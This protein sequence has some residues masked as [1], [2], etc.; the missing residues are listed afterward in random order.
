MKKTV[1]AIAFLGM[2]SAHA[3][4]AGVNTGSSMTMG[5]SSTIYSIQSAGNNPAMNS[6][7]VP[8]SDSWRFSYFPD[9]GI[10]TE[11]GEVDNFTDDLD[12]LIDIIDDP[13]STNDSPSEVLNRF[14]TTLEAMGE[15]GYL[16]ST[17]GFGLPLPRLV[18]QSRKFG[19]SFGVSASVQGQAGLR[20]L[21]S[22]LSFDEQNGTFSTASSLYLKSGIEKSVSLSYSQPL[23]E[24]TNF[25]YTRNNRLYG[26]VSARL[27]SLALSKQVTPL[28]QLD[29]RDVSNLLQDEYDNNLNETV[30]I[31]LSVG[32]VWDAVRYRVGLTLDNINSPSFDYGIIGT[33][34]EARQENTA[35]RTNCE[36]AAQFIQQDG[37]I[38]ARETHTMHARA[39]VD[40]LYHINDRWIASGS[41]DLARY[42]DFV[43]FE[44][45]W[46]NVATSYEFRNNIVPSVRAGYQ[47]NLAGEK[48]G[49]LT[50]GMNFLKYF[51]LDVEYGLDS[52]TVNGSSIPRRFG[53]AFGVEE[54]F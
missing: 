20:I 50:F 33:N 2:G 35:A 36:V 17:V 30:G 9:F 3:G 21:D 27:I 5:P 37:A 16:K 53:F 18:Y 24:R 38:T 39:R 52:T 12:D 28:Q 43:S 23:L 19:G 22:S 44:N 54:R 6:L 26:G 49:S 41:I 11:F 45:Q 46:L 31:G 4:T 29:G 25:R 40:G 8:S 51:S 34:C 48:L 15:S 7:L 47:K 32:V 14:N 13:A 42:N 10:S 1:M